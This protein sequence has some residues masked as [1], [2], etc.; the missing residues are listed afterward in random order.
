VSETL[1]TAL[2]NG[3]L[4]IDKLREKLGETV[5]PVPIGHYAISP[6]R[7]D[8]YLVRLC[9][10]RRG[11][12]FVGFD[13]ECGSCSLQERTSPTGKKCLRVVSRVSH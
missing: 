13:D 5:I 9:V 3:L 8:I 11:N 6:F 2:A 1:Y 7:G 10:R 4:L 12:K